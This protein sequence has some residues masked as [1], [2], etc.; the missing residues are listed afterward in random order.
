VDAFSVFPPTRAY[1]NDEIRRV[2]AAQGVDGVLIINVGDTGVVREYAGTLFTGQY[3]GSSSATGQVTRF[4]NCASFSATG[5]SSGAMFATATPTYRY[6]RQKN[7]NARLMEASSSR[8]LWVGNG[9]V[10]AGGLLFMGDGVSA[11]N[12]TS[13]IFDDLAQKGILDGTS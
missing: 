13:A 1:S 11:S 6:A 10:N 12:S 5:T 2:L 8:N 3:S 7:F 4:G 9:Q